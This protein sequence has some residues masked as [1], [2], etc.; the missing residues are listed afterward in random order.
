MEVNLANGGFGREVGRSVAESNSHIRYLCV[1]ECSDPARSGALLSK[2]VW[3]LPYSLQGATASKTCSHKPL[4]RF[5]I[6]QA[7]SDLN[8]LG[9]DLPRV[10]LADGDL[11]VTKE[12]I[13]DVALSM[14]AGLLLTF[15]LPQRIHSDDGF[16]TCQEL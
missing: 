2:L 14:T 5:K 16:V 10:Q 6:L 7:Q 15:L 4:I 1:V 12:G 11:P 3:A 9:F 13:L 8:F